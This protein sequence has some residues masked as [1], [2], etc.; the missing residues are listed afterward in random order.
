[1]VASAPASLPPGARNGR[2]RGARG[3]AASS[4]LGSSVTALAGASAAPS[5]AP[6]GRRAL[7]PRP[8]GGSTAPR[9]C[10]QPR[11][12]C[13]SYA[14]CLGS[15][16]T[17][18]VQ[19]DTS[20][21]Q[22]EARCRSS[23]RLDDVGVASPTGAAWVT[24]WLV[25]QGSEA[26]E[27]SALELATGDRPFRPVASASSHLRPRTRPRRRSSRGCDQRVFG[28]EDRQDQAR[29]VA[30]ALAAVVV[31]VPTTSRPRARSPVASASPSPSVGATPRRR[32]GGALL[33]ASPRAEAE[34]SSSLQDTERS[35]R[36]LRVGKPA[37][38]ASLGVRAAASLG[39]LTT[40]RPM[41]E[42]SS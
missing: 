29:V 7:R 15:R 14:A 18:T 28:V 8:P 3:P 20:S 31:P 42:R 1:M 38:R 35:R 25:R 5:L 6:P 39:L 24:A 17:R 11:P 41:A 40:P 30:G 36:R 37:G 34:S 21:G 19:Q 22:R 4:S 12:G 27:A 9:A 23:A 13:C 26:E 10:P 16:A 33:P 32:G 2:R